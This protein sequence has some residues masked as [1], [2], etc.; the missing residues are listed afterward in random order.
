MQSL[1]FAALTFIA[2]HVAIPGTAVRELVVGR[3]GETVYRFL[4][5]ILSLGVFVWLITAYIGAGR[6]Y[7]DAWPPLAVARPLAGVAMVLAV[8]LCV[9][10]LTAGVSGPET[11]A[12]GEPARD[13]F[14]ISRRPVLMGVQLWAIAHLVVRGEVGFLI[15]FGA[16]AVLVGLGTGQVDRRQAGRAGAAWPAYAGATS[17]I[18]FAAI[19]AGRNRLVPREIGWRRAALAAAVYIALLLAH[20]LIL[21]V[22]T[23]LI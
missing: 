1:I 10:G 11:A 4:F 14:R 8:L 21:G 23:R 15:L 7:L 22:P 5:A 17:V 2:I 16:F 13:I 19:A 12:A 6:I 20:E 3:V 9:T 18:P